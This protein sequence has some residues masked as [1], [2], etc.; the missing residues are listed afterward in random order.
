MSFL[1]ILEVF[2]SLEIL[3]VFSSLEILKVLSYSFLQTSLT[4]TLSALYLVISLLSTC[5]N[6]SLSD[7]KRVQRML[8]F[9]LDY[10]EEFESALEGLEVATSVLG[11]QS[12]TASSPL[13]WKTDK[14]REKIVSIVLSNKDIEIFY[15][16]MR[17]VKELGVEFGEMR[18]K[19]L[20]LVPQMLV[21][22]IGITLKINLRRGMVIIFPT[23][24]DIPPNFA[25]DFANVDQ[26]MDSWLVLEGSSISQPMESPTQAVSPQIVSTPEARSSVAVSP[27][28]VK[29][30][31]SEEWSSLLSATEVL[32]SLKESRK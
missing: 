32:K 23:E 8:D 13:E 9:L 6:L 31:T 10:W 24:Q 7:T 19:F 1:E 15:K 4:F 18:E 28:V 12:K 14:E 21:P 29:R 11:D 27:L 22:Q 16:G 3:E 20:V 5:T 26:M 17:D 25:W 2:S 30:E